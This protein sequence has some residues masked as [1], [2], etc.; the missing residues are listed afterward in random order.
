MSRGSQRVRSH[1]LIP[2]RGLQVA[3]EAIEH[4]PQ[5][6]SGDLTRTPGLLLDPDRYLPILLRHAPDSGVYLTRRAPEADHVVELVAGRPG[7]RPEGTRAPVGVGPGLRLGGGEIPGAEL[8]PLGRVVGDPE[9][10]AAEPG[11]GRARVPVAVQQLLAL[12][13]VQLAEAPL[14]FLGVEIGLSLKRAGRNSRS[15]GKPE[16][17]TN[18]ALTQSCPSPP[19]LEDARIRSGTRDSSRLAS[20]GRRFRECR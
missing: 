6:T 2:R 3:V 11:A 8:R 20:L 19:G 4:L 10:L 12:E 1:D 15:C 17:A 13:R 5:V 14:V 18:L 7:L 9:P 16:V